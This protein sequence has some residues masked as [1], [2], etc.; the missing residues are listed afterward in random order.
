MF[1]GHPCGHPHVGPLLVREQAARR[2][3][4]GLPPGPARGGAEKARGEAP[5]FQVYDLKERGCGGEGFEN[6]SMEHEAWMHRSCFDVCVCNFTI[7]AEARESERAPKSLMCMISFI[8][9]S[10]GLCHLLYYGARR[11]SKVPCV[12]FMDFEV[13]LRRE[14]DRARGRDTQ[15]ERAHTRSTTKYIYT[16]NQ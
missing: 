12:L 7:R 11:A 13:V 16:P 10:R 6:L 8:F 3:Q 4:A 1:I 2:G 9:F 15:R 5:G 14:R